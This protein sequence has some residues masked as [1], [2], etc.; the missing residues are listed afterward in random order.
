MPTWEICGYERLDG[1]RPVS[2]WLDSQP[3]RVVAA[4]NTV[5]M[6]MRWKQDWLRPENK[7]FKSMERDGTGL[8]QLSFW[9]ESTG[10]LKNWGDFRVA[11]VYEPEHKLFVMLAGFEK[12]RWTKRPPDAIKRALRDLEA[13]RKGLGTIYEHEL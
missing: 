12:R 9:P 2:E 5:L 8:H 3:S 10:F 1:F 6:N 13:Y 4:L 11:G 7:F